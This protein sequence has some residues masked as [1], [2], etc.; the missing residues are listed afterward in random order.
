[1]AKRVLIANRGEIAIRVARAVRELGWEPITI[2]TPED[3]GSPHVRAGRVSLVVPSYTDP[4]A[5]VEAGVKAGADIVHPGY[6]F[7][8]E[9][10]EF[11][12]KVLDAGMAWAGPSPKAMEVLGD[13]KLAKE[14]AEKAGVP[15][16]P[17]CEA[18]SEEEAVRC[19][20]RIG[21]PVI[22]KASKAGGGRGLRVAGSEEEVRRAYRLIRIEAERGFGRGSTIF[23]EKYIENPHH[24]EVQILGD[25]YGNIIHLYEREC[26]IQRRRQKI[27]EEA[28]SPYVERNPSLRSSLADYA[29]RLG[30]AVGYYSAGTVEFVVN[31]GKAYFIEANTRLQVEHGVT[32]AVT[33]I[34]IVKMQLLIADGRELGVRQEDVKVRGW[35]VEARIYAEDPE[36]GFAASEGVLTRVRFPHAPGVR[37]DAGVEEGVRISSKYDTLLAK[38]IAWGASRAEAVAR[39][40]AAL[41]ETVIAG[42]K[43]NLDLLRVIVEQD[44]FRRGEYHT[45]LLESVL[46]RLLEEVRARRIALRELVSALNSRV[47]LATRRAGSL[48][49]V[50]FSHG[51]PWPPWR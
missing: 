26:S 13:K 31:G 8:S 50:M 4:D 22:L 29:L 49:S 41:S 18:A 47:S 27:V 14:V 30:E 48:V 40:K 39:L 20:E 35:A 36:A 10:P 11:A 23:V 7:L 2:Y 12:R 25:Q 6:G 44:W 28:P 51:W 38:I 33:G 34:D 43:T 5:I 32:E 21:Y 16:L 19:A 17:W 1:M 15:T 37:V 42:V 3:A 45:R 46:D 24:I 9:N